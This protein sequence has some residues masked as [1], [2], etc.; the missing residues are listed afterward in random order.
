MSCTWSW[1]IENAVPHSSV[2]REG[3]CKGADILWN[4]LHPMCELETLYT[5]LSKG[6]NAWL[7]GSIPEEV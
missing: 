3:I 1:L 2:N 5:I 4:V 6:D 7:E